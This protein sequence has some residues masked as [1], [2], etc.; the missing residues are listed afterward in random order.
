MELTIE[1]VNP[2]DIQPWSR[3]PRTI[4]EKRFRQLKEAL[5]AHP[6]HMD[7]RPLAV[8]HGTCIAG[9]MRLLAVCELR[10][11]G[12]F[13]TVPA[14]RVDH[15]TAPQAEAWAIRD[16]QPYGED[17]EDQMAEMLAGLMGKID[18]SLTGLADDA[19]TR[20]LAD[21]GSLGDIGDPQPVELCPTCGQPV[22]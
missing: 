7:A 11:E 17:Q 5:R 20:L 9:N 10:A 19:I 21:T 3:N 1:R 18:L 12:L 15:L 16:N 6:E 22:P 2:L 14:V 13:V 4:S 8:W